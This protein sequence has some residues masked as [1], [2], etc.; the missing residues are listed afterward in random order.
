[1]ERQCHNDPANKPLPPPEYAWDGRPPSAAATAQVVPQLPDS[2]LGYWCFTR[3]HWYPEENIEPDTTP[4]VRSNAF[5]CAN[6]GGVRF[7]RHGS[8][9]N[10]QFGRFEWRADCKISK[11]ERIGN[12]YRVSADCTA[13]RDIFYT[14]EDSQKP[15]PETRFFEIWRAKPGLRWRE[16]E[17]LDPKWTLDRRG[18]M[19]VLPQLKSSKEQN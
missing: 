13:D 10:L 4:L 5:N 1:V 16:S 6:L 11:I 14:G 3:S 2:M 9:T 18:L 15:Q 8:K 17:M 7:W 19:K 12:K